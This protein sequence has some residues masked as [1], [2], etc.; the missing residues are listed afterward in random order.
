MDNQL[1]LD[2]EA[3]KIIDG[4]FQQE[5]DR[6]AQKRLNDLAETKLEG[7]RR[8]A[9]NKRKQASRKLRGR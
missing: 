8:M 2:P 4:F 5:M 3:K 7:L 9:R 1:P 6:E